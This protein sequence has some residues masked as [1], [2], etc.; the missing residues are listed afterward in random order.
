[1]NKE[2]QPVVEPCLRPPHLPLGLPRGPTTHPLLIGGEASP[3][4]PSLRFCE[5]YSLTVIIEMLL[6]NGT[7]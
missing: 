6:Y 1:M 4:A 7:S 5:K 2:H 3:D